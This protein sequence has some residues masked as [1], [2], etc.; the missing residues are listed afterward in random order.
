MQG[1]L[2]EE[3]SAWL[4]VLVTVVMG[5]AAAWQTGRAI[6]S[7]WKPQL[8]LIGYMLLLGAAVR[9]THFAL[10]EGTLLSL[11]FYIV[12]T[13]IVTAI[14][15]IG[16]RIARSQQMLRQYDWLYEANGPGRWKRK[17]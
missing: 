1:I 6:A 9:F 8:L 14:A 15:L 17:G 12:D 10:F 4:F 13:V 11:R 2:Y 3:S 16:W 7:V 5:G